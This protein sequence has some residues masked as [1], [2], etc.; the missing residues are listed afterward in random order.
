M[1][2]ELRHLVV[3]NVMFRVLDIVAVFDAL[4]QTVITMERP[5]KDQ[6]H[7]PMPV[8]GAE[9]NMG[10]ANVFCL[11]VRGLDTLL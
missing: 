7:V 5:N 3:E 6:W 10:S 4:I 9:E 1:C 8:L 11:S 2:D